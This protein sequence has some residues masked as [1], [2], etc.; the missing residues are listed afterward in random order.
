[1][2]PNEDRKTVES[3]NDDGDDSE[4]KKACILSSDINK[5][6]LC[7]N[8]HYS[9]QTTPIPITYS[10]FTQ[11]NVWIFSLRKCKL[12]ACLWRMLHSP[13]TNIFLVAEGRVATRPSSSRVSFT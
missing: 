13:S 7:Y 6:K 8:F 12:H 4:S 9:V 3:D 2:S 11:F 10:K 5:R 1:M